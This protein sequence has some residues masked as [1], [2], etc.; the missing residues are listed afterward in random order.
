[1]N[2]EEKNKIGRD[3]LSKAISAANWQPEL[4]Y[5]TSIFVIALLLII[6]FPSA[7]QELK[8]RQVS[9]KAGDVYIQYELLDDDL[10]HRY[11]IGLYTSADDYINPVTEVEGDAGIDLTI[12]GNKQIIWH[13]SKELG[14]DYNGKLA[15]EV[16]G[17]LYVPFVRLNDFENISTIKRDR[18][19]QVTWIAGR[20]SNVLT[21]DLFNDKNEVVHTFTNIANVGEYE[22]TIPKDIKPGKGYYLRITDQNNKEDVVK[23]PPFKIAR[24]VPLYINAGIAVTAAIVGYFVIDSI[25]SGSPQGESGPGLIPD[26]GPPSN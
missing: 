21:W 20:G 13:A 26:I 8:I 25:G 17:K 1:M 24:K 4:K 23:T 11:V 22:L 15:L 6:S 2:R 5:F 7:A 16:K 14:A 19:K 18:P 3:Y 9:V 12:G 10:S